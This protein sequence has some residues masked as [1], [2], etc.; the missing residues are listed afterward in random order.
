V[1]ARPAPSAAPEIEPTIER[2]HRLQRYRSWV[3]R[4]FAVA[5]ACWLL[6]P[7]SAGA[8][9]LTGRVVNGTTGTS[10]GHMA[11]KVV[12][13]SG[14]MLVEK[15]VHTMDALGNY[16]I[17]DLSETVP[18][19]LVRVTY[20][21]VN[22]TEVIR[23]D[24]TDPQ[25]LDIKVYDRTNVWEGIEITVPH[26]MVGRSADTLTV[27][28]FVQVSNTSS[29]P[30]TVYSD[31]KRLT[32]F[33]PPDALQINTVSVRAFGVPLPVSPAPTSEPGFYSIDYPVRPGV[34][35]VQ[36]SFDLPY[37]GSHYHYNEPLRDD[38]AELLVITQDPSME[39]KS[40]A[41]ELGPAE[42]FH[43]FKSYTLRDLSAG[44]TLAL[45]FSGGA[46]ASS[47]AGGGTTVLIVPH[48]TRDLALGAMIV[49]IMALGFYL[50][51]VA[52]KGHSAQLESEVLAI[53]KNELLDQLARLDD[54][55][56]TGTVTDQMYRLKRAELK[57]ALA[58]IYYRTRHEKGTE[59]AKAKGKG[60]VRV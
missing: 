24:G 55:H 52:R 45:A 15:E 25:Q 21:D 12:N 7:A 22:Y 18:V 23:F 14:G 59:P 53:Q 60:T 20:Q 46:S 35:T 50:V 2:V 47:P 9:R 26:M 13:P 56:K 54:L 43:G 57:N 41:T 48:G 28:K 1:T 39:V 33:I 32:L 37:A 51:S 58:G 11:I 19:Y 42:D 44:D 17:D 8:F 38:V 36:V 49:L 4:P 27:E 40:T 16:Q 30:K 3:T 10:V 5:L 29:P 31:D 6:A 34:T